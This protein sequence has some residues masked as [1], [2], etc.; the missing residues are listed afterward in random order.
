MVWK[1]DSSGACVYRKYFFTCGLLSKKRNI[2]SHAF[3][4]KAHHVIPAYG[5]IPSRYFLW[6]RLAKPSFASALKIKR[7]TRLSDVNL[8][9]LMREIGLPGAG[10]LTMLMNSRPGCPSR[11]V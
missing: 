11:N 1:K 9:V 2:Y 6:S 10:I 7:R 8:S 4:D 3:L 5:F